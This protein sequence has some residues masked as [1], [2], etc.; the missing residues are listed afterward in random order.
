MW[1]GG[2]DSA[3]ALLHPRGLAKEYMMVT[4]DGSAKVR[5]PVAPYHEQGIYRD[6][7]LLYNYDTRI[8]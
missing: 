1:S 3:L 8:Q 4:V 6:G 2:K 5:M 7:V